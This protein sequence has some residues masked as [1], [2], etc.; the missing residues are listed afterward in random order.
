M[1]QAFD[2]AAPSSTLHESRSAIPPSSEGDEAVSI[3]L[4]AGRSTAHRAHIAVSF[5]LRIDPPKKVLRKLVVVR[6]GGR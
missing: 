1:Q 4:Q 6:D 5:Q 2:A 3:S